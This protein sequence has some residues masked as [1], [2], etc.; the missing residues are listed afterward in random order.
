M[1]LNLKSKTV[2]DTLFDSIMLFMLLFFPMLKLFSF[3][4]LTLIIPSISG[5][6][7]QTYFS[8]VVWLIVILSFIYV[9]IRRITYKHIIIFASLLLVSIIFYIV[10][11]RNPSTAFTQDRF[12]NLSIYLIPAFFYGACMKINLA[13]KKTIYYFAIFTFFVS[14]IYLFYKNTQVE[15]SED[16]MGFAYRV[17][18]AVLVIISSIFDK[19]IPISTRVLRLILSF[20]ACVFLLM[21]GTRGP[22]LCIAVY[23]TLTCFKKIGIVKTL[24][25]LFSF[26]LFVLF[27]FKSKPGNA[28]LLWAIDLF[29][30][31]G[32]SVRFLEKFVTGNI[33]DGSGRS[34]IVDALM[35][36]L[37]ESP[38]KIRGLF[39]D[40]VATVGLRHPTINMYYPQGIYAHN[41]YV[42]L[43]FDFGVIIGP[44]LCLLL[45]FG[46]LRA[47]VSSKN[48]YADFVAI[49]IT[50]GFVHLLL[51]S[52][53]LLST[54]FFVLLGLFFCG[55]IYEI[56]NKQM[57][58]IVDHNSCFEDRKRKFFAF[59]NNI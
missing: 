45:T 10:E 16:N 5:V 51:S 47:Y 20:G 11:R 17:L 13:V 43:L 22:I 50:V 1:K 54:Y 6:T 28:I 36:K 44:I 41:V 40:V 25:V 21:Q 23:L 48:N 57:L 15:M 29:E 56:P 55:N 27:L 4:I 35:L 12:I 26:V 39:A 31:I 37:K 8:I 7:A 59:I 3:K 14:V 9:W 49:F 34:Y 30:S 46:I 58:S 53:F 33:T 32:V 38:F 24:I 19:N 2:Q 42:E 52:S 18:P